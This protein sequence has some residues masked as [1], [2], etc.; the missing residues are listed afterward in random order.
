MENKEK[1]KIRPSDVIIMMNSGVTREGIA[2]Y[3]NLDK[4]DLK[5]LFSHPKLKG[6][7]ARKPLSF[8]FVE[9][10]EID[11]FEPNSCDYEET[12]GLETTN[13][14]QIL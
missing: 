5:E 9:D 11:N 6:L 13:L 12:I 4:K 8:E 14:E 1:T 7:R 2:E 10:D 3:Y